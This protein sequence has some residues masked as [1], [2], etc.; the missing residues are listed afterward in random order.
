VPNPPKEL[1]TV[2]GTKAQM[3]EPVVRA[4]KMVCWISVHYNPSTRE[5]S[6]SDV[7]ALEAALAETHEVME[8]M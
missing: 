6:R 7:A 5:W 4:D 1:F 2:Y 3:M 8:D